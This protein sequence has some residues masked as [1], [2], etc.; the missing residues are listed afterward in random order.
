M[1]IRDRYVDDVTVV[2][3]DASDEQTND[4]SNESEEGSDDEPTSDYGFELVEKPK[5][6]M[7]KH[8]VTFTRDNNPKLN[9][10]NRAGIACHLKCKAHARKVARGSKKAEVAVK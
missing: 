7:K 3:T 5:M 10:S 1:C 2:D 8:D 9:T 4:D 6:S